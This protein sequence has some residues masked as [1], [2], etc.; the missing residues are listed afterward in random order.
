MH[1]VFSDLTQAA[2]G[3]SGTTLKGRVSEV[4][5]LRLT[6]RGLDRALAIGTRCHVAGIAGPIA[7]EVVGV[8]ARGAHLLPFGTWLGVGPGAEVEIDAPGQGLR[9]GPGWI[10]RVIDALGRPR[11][12]LGPLR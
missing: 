11:D 7:A 1:T 9:P 6:V 8:D 4:I 2:A 12:G 3:V 10:G 5:G